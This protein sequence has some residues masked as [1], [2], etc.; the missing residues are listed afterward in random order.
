ME[1][2]IV[3]TGGGS[4]GHVT[5]NLALLEDLRAHGYEVHYIGTQD[6]IERTLVQDI[7]YHA[8]SAGKLRRYFSFKNVTDV[9]RLLRG[10]GQAKKVLKR[11]RPSLVFAKGGFVS[12]PVVWAAA[13]LGIPVVLHESDY[14]PGLANRLCAK[15]ADKVCLSFESETLRSGKYIVTGSPLRGQLLAGDRQ[16][17]LAKLGFTPAKSVLLI[18]GGSLGAKAINDVIDA[19]APKLA[20]EYAIVH[21]RGKGNLNPALDDLPDYRQY[22]YLSDELA[23]IYAASDL[24]LARAGA[25]AVFEFLALR[26]PALLV[27]L[28][29]SA[30]R[31]D[32]ILNARYFEKHG[33]SIVLAQEELT[34]DTLESSLAKLAAQK[35]V[36]V[37]NMKAAPQADGTQNVLNVIYECIGDE[38]KIT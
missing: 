3:L 34:P 6:G 20:Q 21:L 4:A 1:D 7:P 27:P 17:A 2:R 16:Q 19:A 9:F 36:L 15:K 11:L 26:L 29:L 10:Y 12:V 35:N 25:N 23:D 33:Y 5:P 8:I 28:P 14:T 18:M 37:E 30:S 13:K 32:Q 38:S 22:E 24:A 31:G